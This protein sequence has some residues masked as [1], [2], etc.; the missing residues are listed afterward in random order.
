MTLNSDA[1]FKEKLTLSFKNDMRNLM[2]FNKSSGKSENMH[3]GRLLLP[4]AYKDS[5]KK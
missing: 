1:E 5:A 3:F 4:I 2:N